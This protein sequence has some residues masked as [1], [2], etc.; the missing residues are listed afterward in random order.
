MDSPLGKFT[1]FK[2]GVQI[3][4]YRVGRAALKKKFDC[5]C[6]NL[7]TIRRHIIRHIEFQGLYPTLRSIYPCTKA[8][9]KVN[10]SSVWISPNWI[11]F[12]TDTCALQPIRTHLSILPSKS[13]ELPF[14]PTTL[15]AGRDHVTRARRLHTLTHPHTRQDSSS[16]LDTLGLETSSPSTSIRA[17]RTGLNPAKSRLKKYSSQTAHPSYKQHRLD[18]VSRSI[19]PRFDGRCRV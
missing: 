6:G 7:S 2:R 1:F 19:R 15:L 17:K 18:V 16:F 8:G 13:L 12:P 11:Q 4:F 14:Y 9:R 10:S 5:P 3:F